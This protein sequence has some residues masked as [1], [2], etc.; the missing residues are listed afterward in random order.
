MH[1]I[2]EIDLKA[3]RVE[4]ERLGV[5]I[6]TASELTGIGP[7]QIS[8]LEREDLDPRVSTVNRYVRFLRR[9]AAEQAGDGEGA[10]VLAGSCP[11]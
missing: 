8:R 3:L 7:S 2:K 11:A 9:M 1:A 4:R 6:E 5:T 10:G